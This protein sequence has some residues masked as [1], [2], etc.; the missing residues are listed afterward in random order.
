MT[1]H[2]TNEL[3]KLQRFDI[4]GLRHDPGRGKCWDRTNVESYWTTI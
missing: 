1:E 2:R 4:D 3:P